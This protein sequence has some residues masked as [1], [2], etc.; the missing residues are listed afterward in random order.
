VGGRLAW[1]RG[2]AFSEGDSVA[3]QGYVMAGVGVGY[4]YCVGCGG[5]T[6]QFIVSGVAHTILLTRRICAW[7][8]VCVC[9]Y[10]LAYA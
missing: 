6:H 5:G 3:S 10:A 4:G 2:L 9:A 8:R 1:G 7:L